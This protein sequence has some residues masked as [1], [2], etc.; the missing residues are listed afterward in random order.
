MTYSPICLFD[1]FHDYNEFLED[2]NLCFVL[3]MAG[4][5]WCDASEFDWQLQWIWA[6]STMWRC[7]LCPFR[8]D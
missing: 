6:L 5:Y 1:V 7:S 2:L 4:W 8:V 3:W